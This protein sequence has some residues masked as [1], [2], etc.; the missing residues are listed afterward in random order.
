M[1]IIYLGSS[2]AV[3]LDPPDGSCGLPLTAADLA[4]FVFDLLAARGQDPV[5]TPETMDAAQHA[6]GLLLGAFNVTA[7]E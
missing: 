3:S 2:G 4:A 5:L 1:A 6:A 7:D